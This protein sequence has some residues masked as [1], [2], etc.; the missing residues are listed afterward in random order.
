M[1]L[2]GVTGGELIAA[3]KK[4]HAGQPFVTAELASRLLRH[5]KGGPLLP[6]RG[7]A[8]QAALS[9]HEQQVLAHISKGR[10]NREIARRVG[11]DDKDDQILCEASVQKIA[12]H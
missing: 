10:S 4:I 8:R 12:S 1:L 2:K 7:R 3:R 9:G 6:W 5:A 11:R